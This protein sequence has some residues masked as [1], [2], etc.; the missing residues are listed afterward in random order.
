MLW[1]ITII[2]FVLWVLGMVSGAQLG[3]WIHVLLIFALVSLVLA[4]VRRGRAT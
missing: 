3:T 1:A 4:V 2:L